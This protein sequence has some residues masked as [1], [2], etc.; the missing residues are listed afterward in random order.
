MYQ[1][2]YIITFCSCLLFSLAQGQGVDEPLCKHSW[3]HIGALCK[4]YVLGR[5]EKPDAVYSF[6]KSHVSPEA[7]ILD[8]GS[9]TGISTRQLWR[10]GFKNVIGLDRDPQMIKE[11]IAAN[12]KI[13]SIKYIQA[14]MAL[15]LPFADEQFDV[16]V[17]TSSFHWFSNPSSI[18]EVE[19]IIKPKGYYFVI[20]GAPRYQQN[21]KPN[22][23]KENIERIM[24][25]FGVKKHKQTTPSASELLEE[26]GFKIIVDATVPYEHYYTK[27]EFLNRMQSLSSWNLVNESQKTALLKKVNQ[28]LDT[29]V[30]EQNRIKKEGSIAVVLAQ[31]VRQK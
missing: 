9:G 19:R 4:H 25:E 17:A 18:K 23:L 30:D 10:N 8:L 21:K 6:L 14:D 15:G 13:C 26:Q 28:Y 20:G 3:S 22:P 1:A 7:A 2:I 27:Q 16:V 31:K 29:I 24:D 12:N 5:K 11:A